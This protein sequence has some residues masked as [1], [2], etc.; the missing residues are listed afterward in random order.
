VVLLFS[1]CC[2]HSLFGA[3]VEGVKYVTVNNTIMLVSPSSDNQH[4]KAELL[5]LPLTDPN[6]DF[7]IKVALLALNDSSLV[8]WSHSASDGTYSCSVSKK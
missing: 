5:T 4:P 6:R 1:L 3:S 8:F 7:C 2:S